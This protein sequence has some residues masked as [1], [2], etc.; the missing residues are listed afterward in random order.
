MEHGYRELLFREYT[1]KDYHLL[2]PVFTNPEVMKYALDNC[3]T[4]K[5]LMDYHKKILKNNSIKKNRHIYEFAVFKNNDYLGFADLTI[6]KKNNSGGI[7]EIGYFL[8]PEFWRKGFGADIAAFLINFCFNN[9]NLHKVVATCNAENTGSIKVMQKNG[10]V[11][12]GFFI[13]Q[14]FKN[15]KWVDEYKFAIL[16]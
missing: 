11:Q 5:Q 9:L 4:E 1:N 16:R 2:E 3:F 10:M 14:R 8:L 6:L 7:A 12:E 15:N 13:N